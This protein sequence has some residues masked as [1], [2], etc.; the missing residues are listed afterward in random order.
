MSQFTFTC[1]VDKM[2]NSDLS[3]FFIEH[4]PK[5]DFKVSFRWVGLQ[6]LEGEIHFEFEVPQSTFD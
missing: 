1:V 5:T 2:S 6:C 3:E 4:L